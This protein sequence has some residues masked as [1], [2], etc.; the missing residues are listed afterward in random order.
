MPPGAVESGLIC[1]APRGDQ[2]NSFQPRPRDRSR[3]LA[4]ADTNA[5]GLKKCVSCCEEM[6]GRG[7]S[8]CPVTAERS[9]GALGPPPAPQEARKTDQ[10][11]TLVSPGWCARVRCG[12]CHPAESSAPARAWGLQVTGRVD[13]RALGPMCP[14]R[15][16]LGC[17]EL[18]EGCG[19]PA[20][21]REPR[22]PGCPE[23]PAEAGEPELGAGEEACGASDQRQGDR[24]AR[25]RDSCPA[26]TEGPRSSEEQRGKSSRTVR[27]N[28]P[29]RQAVGPGGC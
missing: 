10:R 26:G 13:V 2:D 4:N 11:V 27:V 25:P 22:G 29:W 19:L 16:A 24:Q 12:R 14:L 5:R 7:A 3:R 23:R 21:V 9:L 18:G 17:G 15:A 20:G 1:S 8:V 28:G 6:W